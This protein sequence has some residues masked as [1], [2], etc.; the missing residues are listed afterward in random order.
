MS[1][2]DEVFNS[3]SDNDNME[4]SSLNS[5]KL[6]EHNELPGGSFLA[7]GT[8]KST[9][10][11]EK[12]ILELKQDV[13][14][15]RDVSRG[16]R[17]TATFAQNHQF[18]ITAAEFLNLASRDQLNK[19]YIEGYDAIAIEQL[20]ERKY[21]KKQRFWYSSNVSHHKFKRKTF[22]TWIKKMDDPSIFN[23]NTILDEEQLMKQL[24]SNGRRR[25]ALIN[26]TPLDA[27]NE[28]QQTFSD[29]ESESD[30]EAD[31]STKSTITNSIP[32]SDKSIIELNTT[33]E[34]NLSEGEADSD[35]QIPLPAKSRA[36]HNIQED[37]QIANPTNE[38]IESFQNSNTGSGD[39]ISQHSTGDLQLESETSDQLLNTLFDEVSNIES[40][41]AMSSLKRK[42][43]N[44]TNVLSS[45]TQIQFEVE[46]IEIDP[47]PII[48]NDSQSVGIV[49]G[50]RLRHRNIVNRNPYMVDRAE[51]LGLSTPVELSDMADSGKTDDEIIDYL[52]SVYQKRRKQ[53]KESGYGFGPY[54]KATFK[55]VMEL[56]LTGAQVS[57]Q[58]TGNAHCRSGGAGVDDDDFQIQG[59]QD[60]D[61]EEEDYDEEGENDPSIDDEFDDTLNV[62][63][64]QFVT[65]RKRNVDRDD[66]SLT[67]EQEYQDDEPKEVDLFGKSMDHIR[68]YMGSAAVEDKRS[69]IN[70]LLQKYA[71]STNKSSGKRNTESKGRV[72]SDKSRSNTDRLA[73]IS[74]KSP[75]TQQEIN[76]F[77][78]TYKA[79]NDPLL[80]LAFSDNEEYEEKSSKSTSIREAR[81]ETSNKRKRVDTFLREVPTLHRASTGIKDFNQINKAYKL[82][83]MNNVKIP[84]LPRSKSMMTMKKSKNIG[85][86]N[87]KSDESDVEENKE[88]PTKRPKKSNNVI[89]ASYAPKT[90][91]NFEFNRDIIKGSFQAEGI[92]AFFRPQDR[93]PKIDAKFNSEAARGIDVTKKSRISRIADNEN[94]KTM[95]KLWNIYQDENNV[96]ERRMKVLLDMQPENFAEFDTSSKLLA[97]NMIKNVLN[98][99]STY[100]HKSNIIIELDKS[101]NLIQVPMK[102]TTNVLKSV[103]DF[104]TFLGVALRGGKLTS[105]RLVQIRKS[106]INIIRLCWNL[107]RDLPDILVDVG[108]LINEFMNTL[109][110]H[111]PGSE[112]FCFF[113]PFL[114]VCMFLFQRF[115]GPHSDHFSTFQKS[116]R[117]IQKKFILNFCQIQ[118]QLF[119]IPENRV[120]FEA[121][122][123]FLMF[124]KN[125]WDLVSQQALKLN[126][127]DVT[128][129]L[130][131]MSQT[132]RIEPDWAFYIQHLTRLENLKREN[133]NDVQND[134][135]AK[136]ICVLIIKLTKELGWDL[137]PQ[138]LIKVFRL[139]SANRFINIGTKRKP[140]ATIYPH[141]E[142]GTLI[143]VPEDG[144]LDLYFKMLSIFAQ[145][146]IKNCSS[147]G[148][149]LSFLE[150]DLTP[151]STLNGYTAIQLQNRAKVVLMLWIVFDKDVLA[152]L[153][154]IIE[155]MLKER[156]VYSLK[157]LLSLL[158]LLTTRISRKPI[159]TAL[160]FLPQIIENINILQSDTEL[161]LE[162]KELLGSVKTNIVSDDQ[163]PIK[164][165]IQCILYMMKITTL[166]PFEECID[167]IFETV[168][169]NWVLAI[170]I[171]SDK[172]QQKINKL[173]DKLANMSRKKLVE[174]TITPN[175]GNNFLKYWM[176]SRIKI[177]MS[178]PK[179]YYQE[180]LNIGSQKI[181]DRF[182]LSFF[183]FLVES[184][185]VIDIQG[186][187]VA[188]FYKYLANDK[189][190]MRRLTQGVQNLNILPIDLSKYCSLSTEEFLKRRTDFTVRSLS[191]LVSKY[192]SD[193][194]S[195]NIMNTF[196]KSLKDRYEIEID[197]QFIK[198]VAIYIYTVMG[199]QVSIPEWKYLEA[200]LKLETVTGSL[201]KQIAYAN[202]I[203]TNRL[204]TSIVKSYIAAV[205]NG[206][207]A[208]FTNDFKHL[209]TATESSHKLVTAVCNILSFHVNSIK[210]GNSEFE[211]IHISF[212]L[213]IML[214]M[215]EYSWLKLDFLSILSILKETSTLSAYYSKA[216]TCIYY[217]HDSVRVIYCII[218]M[219]SN[220][221]RGFLEGVQL[222]VSIKLFAGMDTKF[223]NQFEYYP[224]KLIT[225]ECEDVLS[226]VFYNNSL[227]LNG[228]YYLVQNQQVIFEMSEKVDKE[229]MYTLEYLQIT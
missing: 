193:D 100:Y 103:K 187:V 227:L 110:D 96:N 37:S 214:S 228:K 205:I 107:K 59:Q 114:L 8:P 212:W 87:N 47:L 151:G 119:Y 31:E 115:L 121:L 219:L 229:R 166:E 82:I 19:L 224:E 221:L 196:I 61:E 77:R 222:R 116:A 81:R 175:L 5:S 201:S 141:S 118:Y 225:H 159:V 76:G 184:S 126:P 181:K 220:Q 88:K 95:R 208:T 12:T 130:Y 105:Q 149:Q 99:N 113:S 213:K 2:L 134:K 94:W 15:H 54:S 180:W 68:D 97:S 28:N 124:S 112:A 164:Y 50:R 27:F 210:L 155:V 203:S 185:S 202:D 163:L 209:F 64:D 41:S 39:G 171:A 176:F 86:P 128:C 53:R 23:S 69:F 7:L 1:D 93:D 72:A 44:V 52:D 169:N 192:S 216:N 49:P 106:L 35:S 125:P 40:V 146:Y 90:N 46:G 6:G 150:T 62:I 26:A 161:N 21:R 138:V 211:W 172:D 98:M 167:S 32:Q 11:R 51:Y 14:N 133:V 3:Q 85:S 139:L 162:F 218:R 170:Q 137:D 147:S 22:N 179:I 157:S 204:I 154:N 182:E 109:R 60:E 145:S 20:L 66:V 199:D 18:T 33:G 79:F 17:R 197:N 45:P 58:E 153:T 10:K 16:R 78:N 29:E 189:A 75:N 178:A 24:D 165:S 38:E 91:S 143:S 186:E 174:K 111:P 34:M 71:S 13:E 84:D 144:C 55:E 131:F 188:C 30:D 70:P 215:L 92:S 226:K 135:Q 198:D 183:S 83:P 9:G 173:L 168:A 136:E 123:L 57:N 63:N 148:Y 80:D 140:R 65:K 160:K 67:T 102:S 36:V 74:R 4:P 89:A 25:L 42:S 43:I 142:P 195:K 48:Q 158:R 152:Y 190:D 117:W 56:S 191:V 101:S 104:F 129:A 132:E 194:F 156:S 120:Y 177:N 122:N 108:F 73:Y 207:L 127:I 217:Y 206:E 223:I 200:K